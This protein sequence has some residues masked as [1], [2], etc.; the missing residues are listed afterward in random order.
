MPH[1]HGTRVGAAGEPDTASPE[2]TLALAVVDRAIRDLDT[3]RYRA[4]ALAWLSSEDALRWLEP[5]GVD[6]AALSEAFASWPEPVAAVSVDKGPTP[7][8]IAVLRAAASLEDHGE[9][10]TSTT[11]R[12][13]TG[14][15]AKEH[16]TRLRKCGLLELISSRRGYKLTEEGRRVLSG[17]P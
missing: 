5:L 9:P 2:R 11:V 8:A 4:G 15:R 1:L 7:A 13:G 12:E 6:Q 10:V 16:L 3:V 14:R 17:L